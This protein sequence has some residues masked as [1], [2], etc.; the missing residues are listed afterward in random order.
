MVEDVEEALE[1]GVGVVALALAGVFGQ[2]QRQRAVGAGEAEEVLLDARCAIGVVLDAGEGR[3]GETAVGLLPQAQ[4]VIGQAH[5]MAEARALGEFALDTAQRL[6]EV[7]VPGRG[8][9]GREGVHRFGRRPGF[10]RH[11]IT[12]PRSV[13]RITVSVKLLIDT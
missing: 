7:V 3:G 11:R 9:H 8:L 5:G 6:E 4:R 2:V 13:V 10:A 1:G 12:S